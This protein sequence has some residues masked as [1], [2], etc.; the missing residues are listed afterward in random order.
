MNR[1]TPNAG[2]DEDRSEAN[3]P[4][5][6]ATADPVG[7]SPSSL[8]HLGA[9]ETVD[10]STAAAE[11]GVHYQTAY[12]WVRI[13]QLAAS[14][15]Q[16]SYQVRRGDVERLAQERAMPVPPPTRR[17]I[18]QWDSYA[19]RLGRA[20]QDGNEGAARQ[21]SQDLVEGGALL[22]EICDLVYT[23]AL[24]H[25]G[26][27]WAAGEVSIAIEHRAVAICERVLGH[28]STF[29]PGRPRGVALVVA[30]PG[31]EHHLPALMATVA[32]REDRWRV[33]HVGVNVPLDDVWTL[34]RVE[35]AH[36]VVISRTNPECEAAA[37]AMARE[38][39]VRGYR[40]L[41]GAPGLSLEA[42]VDRARRRVP[43]PLPAAD[44]HDHEPGHGHGLGQ[45][46]NGPEG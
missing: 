44:S 18:R 3:A 26:E 46:P 16:G 32:L 29:P 39:A 8:G 6:P 7:V 37:E 19:E 40:A 23:P 9:D 38:A 2:S 30:P 17:R 42:L 12:R 5:R 15:V 25:L 45:G 41:V 11:L 33:H 13:G 10:L 34:A 20:L 1:M 22:R 21:L 35:Q 24:V 43:A 28:L 36:L 31:D 14:K 4:A 27:A